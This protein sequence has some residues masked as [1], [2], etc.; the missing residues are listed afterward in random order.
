[1]PALKPPSDPKALLVEMDA[2]IKVR[3]IREWERLKRQ[4]EIQWW[5]SGLLALLFISG[6][7][8]MVTIAK[9]VPRDNPLLYGFILT[10][11]GLFVLAVICS[12]EF[13]VLKF[14]ALRRMHEETARHQDE[15][16]ATLKAIRDYL[17]AREAA[18]DRSR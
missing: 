6:L 15:L 16:Q 5:E 11:F 12:I 2:R 14:R 4:V 9:L 7:G 18:D 13:L 8:M 10:W 3:D 1:M 17:E